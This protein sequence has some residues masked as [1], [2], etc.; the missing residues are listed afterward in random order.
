VDSARRIASPTPVGEP[1]SPRLLDRVRL[2]IRSHHYSPR[3]EEAYL[4]WIKRYIF[5]H[6]KRHPLLTSS[7]MATISGPCES[8]WGTRT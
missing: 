7:K 3:T 2:A 4:A 6:D 1:Q 8:C 5:F